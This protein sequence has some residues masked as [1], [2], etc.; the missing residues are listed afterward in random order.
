MLSALEVELDKI[1]REESRPLFRHSLKRDTNP[2]RVAT[3]AKIEIALASF[4]ELVDRSRRMLGYAAADTR[5]VQSLL[6]WNDG[7]ACIPRA[8]A[9]YLEQTRD[10]CSVAASASS[11]ETQVEA[12][13]ENLLIWL[14]GG[15]FCTRN[16]SQDEQVKIVPKPS[17]QRAARILMAAVLILLLSVPVI[18][19]NAVESASSRIAV[20]LFATIVFIVTLSSLTRANA[21]EM[22]GAGAAYSAVLVV[23]ASGTS[24][25]LG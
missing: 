11:A 14:W 7:T 10:L 12:W 16:V 2:A 23:F 4:D 6:N 24:P 18:L 17:L 15:R 20:V 8:E 5:E 9:A 21:V 13:V 1:D 22:F 19:C 3:L 25:L